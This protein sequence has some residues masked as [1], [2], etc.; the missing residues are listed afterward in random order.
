VTDLARQETIDLKGGET[1]QLREHESFHGTSTKERKI[2]AERE[3]GRTKGG[4]EGLGG[5]G[6]QRPGAR[7]LTSGGDEARSCAGLR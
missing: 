3:S 7:L 4:V 5:P 2:D 6:K 1:A